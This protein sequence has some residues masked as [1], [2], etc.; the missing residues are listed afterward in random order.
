VL[1]PVLRLLGLSLCLLAGLFAALFFEKIRPENRRALIRLWTRSLLRALGVRLRVSGTT[2]SGPGLIVANHVS[3]LDVIALAAL[4]PAVFIC[5]SEIADWPGIGWLLKQVGTIFIRRG[6]LRDVLR[7]NNEL[8]D[9]FGARQAVAAFPEGTTSDGSTVLP[10]RSALFQPAVERGLPV[11][12]AALAYS[13][14]AAG[15]LGDTSFGASLLAIARASELEVR[16]TFL[17]PLSAPGLGRKRA[18][19]QARDAI[20]REARALESLREA[21]MAYTPIDAKEAT[22]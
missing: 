11:Y 13:S 16:V 7:V 2:P 22:R 12:P 19:V 8:R 5:K 4:C 15:Y 10:F 20:S 18:A 1:L 14:P 17:P 9:R 6:S 21:A 3:W